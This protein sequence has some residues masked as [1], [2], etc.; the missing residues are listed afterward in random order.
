MW[1]KVI[2][3]L[4]E[5]T[6]IFAYDRPGYG[7][8]KTTND[9]RSPC[10]IAKELHTLLELA[11]I[12]PPYILVGHSLGG[13]YQYCFARLF[14]NDT[15]ALVLLDP[16]HPEHWSRMKEEAP[17]Q[18]NMIKGLRATMFSKTMREEFDD[19]ENCLNIVK[20]NNPV[21]APTYL[22]FSGKFKIEEQGAFKNM[23]KSLRHDWSNLF[24]SLEVID[25]PGSGHYIQ[26]ESPDTVYSV[27]I[28][29]LNKVKI[30]R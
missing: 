11:N 9:E 18:A 24:S 28:S 12:P 15:A 22:L 13:L 16:T 29:V 5:S 20:S 26:T 1:K 14:P 30:G 4:P 8:S 6:R 10:N 17:V 2:K 7:D 25:V 27:I 21:V 19:Q 3:E 23:V